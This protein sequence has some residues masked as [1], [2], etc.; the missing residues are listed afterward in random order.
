LAA[1]E[2][3]HSV[4]ALAA[5]QEQVLQVEAL[6]AAVQELVLQV[7]APEAA[8]ELSRLALAR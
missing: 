6:L 4:E 7:E 1:P 2:L 3:V 8:L 5:V